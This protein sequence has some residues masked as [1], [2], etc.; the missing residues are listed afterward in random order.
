M[1]GERVGGGG[2]RGGVEPILRETRK[3]T[4]NQAKVVMQIQ[5][6]GFSFDKSFQRFRVI[7]LFLQETFL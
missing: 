7:L 1:F 2:V 5:V 3:S 4:A 6:L